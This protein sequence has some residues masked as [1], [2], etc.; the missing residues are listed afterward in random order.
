MSHSVDAIF[1]NHFGSLLLVY[2]A[3]MHLL[4]FVTLYYS[5]H[6]V[7]YGCDPA[8]DHLIHQH[9]QDLLEKA[10]IAANTIAASKH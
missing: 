10:V 4:V 9:R 6:Y 3:L 7:H 1:S 5:A 2:L 8:I